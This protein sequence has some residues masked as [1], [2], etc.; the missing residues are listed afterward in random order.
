MGPLL[1]LL[2]RV[3]AEADVAG[4]SGASSGLCVWVVYDHHDVVTAA[5]LHHTLAATG[6]VLRNPRYTARPLLPPRMFDAAPGAPW[7]GLRTFVLNVAYADPQDRFLAEG[8]VMLRGLVAMPGI[9]AFAAGY[10][11]WGGPGVTGAEAWDA[12]AGR[13]HL[14]ESPGSK[15]MRVVVA[16][17]RAGRVHRVARTRGA[18]GV[19]VW[20]D[21]PVRGDLSTSLRILMDTACGRLPA[22]SGFAERYPTLAELERRD[23]GSVFG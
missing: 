9:V 23:P 1:R 16:V 19:E 17:D 15:E 20:E 7:E 14:E 22:P 5:Q 18:P 13:S 2:R 21:S 4:W 3:E 6:A 8:V 11:A 12:A 10:E